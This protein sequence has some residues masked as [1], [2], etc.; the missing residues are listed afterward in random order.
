[1]IEQH[2]WLKRWPLLLL[3]GLLLLLQYQLWFGHGGIL[4]AWSL[5]RSVA[6]EKKENAKLLQRNEQL[7]ADIADLKK[8]HQAVAERARRDLGMIKKGEVFYQVVK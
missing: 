5:E 4:G 8:G 6:F 2:G 3:I 7:V 1:M